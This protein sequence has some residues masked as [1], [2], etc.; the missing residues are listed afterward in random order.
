LPADNTLIRI[1]SEYMYNLLYV[2]K[3]MR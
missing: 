2:G 1:I 3:M